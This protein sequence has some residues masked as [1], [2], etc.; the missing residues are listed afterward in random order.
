[1]ACAP[2]ATGWKTHYR[3]N[4]SSLDPHDVRCQAGEFMSAWRVVKSDD[5]SMLQYSYTCCSVPRELRS[6]DKDASCCCDPCS[7]YAGVGS[8]LSMCHAII[9]C[10]DP[11]LWH[12][13]AGA[14][15]GASAQK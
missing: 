10:V 3:R 9:T 14:G 7:I 4:V 12:R 8:L 6:G 1:M 15:S 13:A 2:R 11:S 5:K